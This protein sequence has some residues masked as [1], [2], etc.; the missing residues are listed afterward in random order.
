MRKLEMNELRS[1]IKE[2]FELYKTKQEY[3]NLHRK[4]GWKPGVYKTPELLKRINARDN[5]LVI[6]PDETIAFESREEAHKYW[7]RLK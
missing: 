2:A 7:E 1:I 4:N 3:P 5:Y 6:F